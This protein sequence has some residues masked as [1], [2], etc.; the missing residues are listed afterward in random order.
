MGDLDYIGMAK[1]YWHMFLVGAILFGLSID[2]LVRFLGRSVR[3]SRELDRS[4]TALRKIR[5]K[6]E[7]DVTD[8]REIGEGAM[9]GDALPHLW[10]EYSKTLHPQRAVDGLGQSRIVRWRSTAMAE[11]FFKIGRAHV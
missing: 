1:A 3:L 2:F 8:L 4:L 6:V 7:G 11:S 10:A 5:S 9:S